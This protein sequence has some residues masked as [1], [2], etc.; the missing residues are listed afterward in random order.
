MS[1]YVDN[2]MFA[3]WVAAGLDANIATLYPGDSTSNPETLDVLPRAEYFS[4]ND[5]LAFESRGT[6]GSMKNY[7]FQVW[8]QTYEQAG[9]FVAAIK[10][11][12]LN[13]TNQPT[14]TASQGRIM[15]VHKDDEGIDDQERNVYRGYFSCIVRWHEVKP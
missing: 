6:L 5:P 9:T 10:A 4:Q 14:L 3:R 2:A 8:T 1:I 7:T 12:M 11:A 13:T 15:S